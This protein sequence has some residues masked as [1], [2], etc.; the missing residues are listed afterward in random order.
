MLTTILNRLSFSD[1]ADC[2][3]MLY[4]SFIRHVVFERKKNKLFCFDAVC[5]NLCYLCSEYLCSCDVL[6]NPVNPF[7]QSS[8][9]FVR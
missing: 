7:A 4:C 1:E 2:T 6:P 3:K 9:K 8:N 5:Q